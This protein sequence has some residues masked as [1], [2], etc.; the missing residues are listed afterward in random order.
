MKKLTV[1]IN[2][3]L[4]PDPNIT[5]KSLHTFFDLPISPPLNNTISYGQS[6][7]TNCAGST[8]S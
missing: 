8:I 2:L 7:E 4:K 6:N 5:F 3:N 1:I